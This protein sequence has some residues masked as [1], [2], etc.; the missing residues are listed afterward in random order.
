VTTVAHPARIF[1]ASLLLWSAT[2]S[3]A[4][5]RTKNQIIPQS[6]KTKDGRTLWL[7]HVGIYHRGAKESGRGVALVPVFTDHQ[8]GAM[9]KAQQDFRSSGQPAVVINGQQG[10]ELHDFSKEQAAITVKVARTNKG[11]IRMPGSKAG[12]LLRHDSDLFNRLL[13]D[14]LGGSTEGQKLRSSIFK[15]AR[16]SSERPGADTGEGN[17]Y[18]LAEQVATLTLNR[19][20]VILPTFWLVGGPNKGWAHNLHVQQLET[21]ELVASWLKKSG[22]MKQGNIWKDG[23]GRKI[24][25]PGLRFRGL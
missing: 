9:T 19:D 14:E 18:V 13:Y 23:A 5:K 10:V 17:H 25:E 24:T 1:A 8:P 3:A 12:L 6:V 11:R 2:A 21:E 22:F 7:D 4:V 15:K 20:A 16:G